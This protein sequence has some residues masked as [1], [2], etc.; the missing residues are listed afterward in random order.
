[1]ELKCFAKWQ[2]IFVPTLYRKLRKRLDSPNSLNSLIIREYK[3]DQTRAS[4]LLPIRLALPL[5][6]LLEVHRRRE[7]RDSSG[8]GFRRAAKSVKELE[9]KTLRLW[10]VLSCITIE[11]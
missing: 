6:K 8:I 3:L 4:V 5:R 2:D 11:S 1:M 10:L 9:S 7:Q